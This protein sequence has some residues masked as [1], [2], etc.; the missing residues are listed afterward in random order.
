MSKAKR[1]RQDIP[2]TPKMES[3]RSEM[4]EVYSYEKAP[5]TISL[6]LFDEQ[7]GTLKAKR[8]LIVYPQN[9]TLPRDLWDIAKERETIKW[10]LDHGK[11]LEA[12]IKPD[13]HLQSIK[14][15]VW[16]NETNERAQRVLL[17]E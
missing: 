11:L 16:V 17:T 9:N 15:E 14:R 12:S 3:N 13:P 7:T 1:H 4:V 8:E 6:N 10:R 5:L 2:L